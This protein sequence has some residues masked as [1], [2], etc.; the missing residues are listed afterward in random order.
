MSTNQ[1]NLILSFN[2]RVNI[3]IRIVTEKY[4]DAVLYEANGKA[5]GGP[6]TK[7]A[8]IDRMRVVFGNSGLSTI[9]IEETAYGEFGEPKLVQEPWLGDTVIDLSKVKLDLG[10]AIERKRASGYAGAFNGVTLRH[11]LHPDCKNPYF[12]FPSSQTGQFIFVDVVT[13]EVSAG[14]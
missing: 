8:D 9:M 4:P 3:A 10:D 11:P 1:D 13:G 14:R 6:A 2:G 12:I 7:A 5:T